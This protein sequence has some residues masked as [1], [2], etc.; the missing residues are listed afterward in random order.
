MHEEREILIKHIFPQL[1]RLCEQRGV[2]WGEVDLR[3]GVTE[4]EA[5]QGKVVRLCLDEIDRCRPYFLGLLGERYGWVPREAD[6]VGDLELLDRHPWVANKVREGCGVTELEIEHG[7]LRAPAGAGTT[8]FY[9]R[10]PS[11]LPHRPSGPSPDDY[12][13]REEGPRQRLAALKRR[14]RAGAAWACADYANP[15]ALGQR[16]LADFTALLDRQYPPEQTPAPGRREAAAHRAFADSRARDYVGRQEQ[17]DRLDAHVTGRGPPLVVFGDPGSGKSALLASWL[18]RWQG[19]PLDGGRLF[20][21]WWRRAVRALRPRVRPGEEHVLLHCVGATPECTTWP[22]LVRRVLGDLIEQFGLTLDIPTQ[23]A[24]LRTALVRGLALAAARGRIVLLLDGLDQLEDQGGPAGLSWLPEEVPSR[25]RLIVSCRR[26]SLLAELRRRHW[27]ELAVKPLGR[28]E[29]RVLIGDFLGRYGKR[30]SPAAVEEIA[31][32]APA[33]TPL[34]LRTLLEELRVLGRHED[35]RA[36]LRH[37][38]GAPTTADLYARVLARWE[39]DFDRDRPALVRDTMTLLWATRTGLTERELLELLRAPGDPLP[40]AVWSPL[41]LAAEALLVNRS[42]LLTF[43]HPEARAAV[44]RAYLSGEEARQRARRRLAAYF[45]SRPLL[46]R[47]I[48]EL[49]WQLAELAAWDELA[50]LLANPQFLS[51][52]W[53]TRPQELKAHWT[54]IEQASPLRLVDTHRALLESPEPETQAAWALTVLLAETGHLN[55]SLALAARLETQARAASDL[56]CV[57]TSLGVRALALARCGDVRAGMNLLR[58]QE[59]LSRQRGD[60]AALAVNLGNQGAFLRD[61]GETER[62]LARHREA[63]QLCRALE[64]WEGVAAALGNQGVLSRDRQDDE[65][66]LDLFRQQE[67]ICRAQGDLAGLQASLGNQAAILRDRRQREKAL[68]LHR[69]EAGLCRLLYDRNGLQKCLGNQARLLQDQEDYDGALVLQKERVAICREDGYREDL[70]RALVQQAWLFG[71]RLGAAE[72]A[73]EL[74]EEALRWAQETAAGPL[75]AE[76]REL[77]GHLRDRV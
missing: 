2:I 23:P 15:A 38:L 16:V 42:G 1:R 66:A 54:R 51:H 65:G 60:R 49:P 37:Y 24:P 63:E 36:R 62:A 50:A 48:E 19:E 6:L 4:E 9:F 7:V 12:R 44:E 25:V 69:E 67:A 53:A 10:D 13:E 77:L 34:Y 68:A 73:R 35:L 39:E 43:V 30:L 74:A 5:R 45:A 70:A 57:Q 33:G 41:Y 40:S 31:G 32:S 3:W 75:A 59:Q 76:I 55:E 17:F 56:A 46:P 20:D 71:V 22:S 18:R 47:T 8:F 29:C 52:A 61:L 64:D 27:A 72:Y 58:Q 28:G 14:L 26:G 11:Y 21:S